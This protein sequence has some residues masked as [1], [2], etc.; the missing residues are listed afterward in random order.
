MSG[1]GTPAMSMNGTQG[2][3]QRGTYLHLAAHFL[4]LPTP[5]NPFFM[6]SIHFRPVFLNLCCGY[7]KIRVGSG[8]NE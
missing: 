7:G 5:G 4:Y 3:T 8:Y 1:I 2:I 6:I